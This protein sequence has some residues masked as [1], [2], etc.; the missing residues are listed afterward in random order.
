MIPHFH[1]L[2]NVYVVAHLNDSQRK[3]FGDKN[4]T[5][6]III[7]FLFNTVNYIDFLYNVH[8]Q[9][10]ACYRNNIYPSITHMMLT[11]M[12]P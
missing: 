6:F 2:C 3:G 7:N 12:L 5:G 1:I 8:T 9:I 4:I 10:C 11:E